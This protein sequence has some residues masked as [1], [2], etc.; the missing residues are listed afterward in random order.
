MHRSTQGFARHAAP[1]GDL[2]LDQI[3]RLLRFSWIQGGKATG[4]AAHLFQ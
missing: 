2:M 4:S 1:T 3:P